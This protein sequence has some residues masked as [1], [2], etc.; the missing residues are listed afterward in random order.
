M[1]QQFFKQKQLVPTPNTMTFR[2]QKPI[3]YKIK[4]KNGPKIAKNE[5]FQKTFLFLLFQ[6]YIEPTCQKNIGL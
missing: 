6:R 1:S 5:N 2:F 4:M 3:F